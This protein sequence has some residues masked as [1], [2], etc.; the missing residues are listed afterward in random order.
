[1]TWNQF[2]MVHNC[3]VFITKLKLLI[4]IKLNNYI[5]YLFV[6]NILS[7]KCVMGVQSSWY[8]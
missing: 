6:W 5:V 3:D 7:L 4:Y 8:C 1:M 2:P